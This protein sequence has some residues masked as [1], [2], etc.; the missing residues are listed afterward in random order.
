MFVP[1]LP[2]PTGGVTHA[3]EAI[4]VILAAQMV[5]GRG[6]IWLPARFRDRELGATMTG[7]ALPFV[8]RRVRQVERFSRPRG[9]WIFR[10]TLAVRVIGLVLIAFAVAAAFAP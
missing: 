6:E 9:A 3:F 10:R 7:K 1:A 4:A 2:L 5:L 8:L